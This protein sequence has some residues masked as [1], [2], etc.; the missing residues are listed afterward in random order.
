MLS[1]ISV[2][3]W[4][5]VNFKDLF[6]TQLGPY[7]VVKPMNQ[8]S[9]WHLAPEN[10]SSYDL[11]FALLT[12]RPDRD[13]LEH[14]PVWRPWQSALRPNETNNLSKLPPL[15]SPQYSS[16]KSL[17]DLAY[18][19]GKPNKQPRPIGTISTALAEYLTIV[20]G[21]TTAN[22][23]PILAAIATTDAYAHQFLNLTK[24]AAISNFRSNIGIPSPSPSTGAFPSV[25]LCSHCQ[26]ATPTRWFIGSPS[27]DE[28]ILTAPFL[29]QCYTHYINHSKTRLNPARGD[30][31]E[32]YTLPYLEN[33][34]QVQGAYVCWPCACPVLC[35]R[36]LSS[37]LDIIRAEK[38]A[39]HTSL[40]LNNPTDCALFLRHIFLASSHPLK[41]LLTQLLR[42]RSVAHLASL[43]R[44]QFPCGIHN[45]PAV[46]ID[47]SWW[48]PYISTPPPTDQEFVVP[49]HIPGQWVI[50]MYSV[51]SESHAPKTKPPTGNLRQTYLPTYNLSRF[52]AFLQSDVKHATEDPS[53]ASS[54][55]PS[56]SLAASTVDALII[57]LALTSTNTLLAYSLTR[58][59][60]MR[61]RL[62]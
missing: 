19:N 6:T 48:V 8:P 44:E 37:K 5:K 43:T 1:E 33:Q 16:A 25:D 54:F 42:T 61:L 59:A 34:F 41:D 62:A 21:I 10:N 46:M 27:D 30:L 60:V 29:Q 50:W 40:D 4:Q 24:L 56:T 9:T 18:P 52:R 35:A 36:L 39:S 14:L 45:H 23:T 22:M 11:S 3:L 47:N 49:G 15:D 57:P 58:E 26:K 53:K 12:P 20:A 32:Q 38:I 51:Q 28:D 55:L 17:H 7:K 2:G 13:P 31:V